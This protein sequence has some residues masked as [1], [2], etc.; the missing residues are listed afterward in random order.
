MSFAKWRPFCLGLNVLMYRY[1]PKKCYI[2]YMNTPI[3]GFVLLTIDTIIN[4][5]YINKDDRYS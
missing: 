1:L 2:T 5:L 3:N 4:A